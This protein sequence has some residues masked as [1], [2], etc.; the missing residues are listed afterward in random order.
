MAQCRGH[1]PMTSPCDDNDDKD[2]D[3]DRDDDADAGNDDVDDDS[4]CV[5]GCKWRMVTV[6]CQHCTH[7]N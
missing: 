7:D 5:G 3:D 4:G 6:M 1:G 2:D